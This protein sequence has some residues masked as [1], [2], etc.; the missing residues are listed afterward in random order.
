MMPLF[1]QEQL[2]A[3]QA[4]YYEQNPTTAMRLLSYCREHPGASVTEMARASGYG[5]SWVRKILR[6]NG[7]ALPGHKGRVKV[8]ASTLCAGCNHQKGGPAA[9]NAR[10]A[11][12]CPGGTIHR[13]DWSHPEPRWICEGPHC[14][15]EGCDCEG[16][17][18]P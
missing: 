15:V 5:K 13:N 8:L 6:D 17:Q 16:F 9:M 3:A 14:C 4:R 18:K 2:D 1:P 12:H 11:S 7:I 10:Q